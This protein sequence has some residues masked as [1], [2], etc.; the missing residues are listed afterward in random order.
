MSK[1]NFLNASLAVPVIAILSACAQ[2]PGPSASAGERFAQDRA[3]I[4]AM[5]GTYHV[6]FDMRET[7]SFARD[8]KI[9]PPK[10]SGGTEVVFVAEDTGATIRLQHILVGRDKDEKLYTIK[11]WRQDWTYQPATVLEYRGFGEWTPS[12]PGKAQAQGAWSQ[13]VWQV[14]DSPRYGGLGRWRYDGN[15]ARWEAFDSTHPLP[16]R[17]AT[18]KPAVP[19]DRFVGMN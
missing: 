8:Y 15:V 9:L 14:D 16:R 12:R 17:D 3:S 4:L 1:R 2:M 11:H 7:V 10:R 19:F 18:R 6:E 13:T 5:T